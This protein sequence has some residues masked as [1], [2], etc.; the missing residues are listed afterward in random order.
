MGHPGKTEMIVSL[1]PEQL[2][3]TT[4]RPQAPKLRR[5]GDGGRS[6]KKSALV[7]SALVFALSAAPALAT[8]PFAPAQSAANA[9][10]DQK[11]RRQRENMMVMQQ[12]VEEMQTTI[13]PARR[14]H[15]LQAH[16]QKLQDNMTLMRNMSE[17]SMKGHGNDGGRPAGGYGST[18]EHAEEHR[19]AMMQE[20]LDML[21]TMMEQMMVREQL[22]A[23]RPAN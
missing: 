4:N 5:A 21:Q 3:P 14:R 10:L 16:R 6:M 17:L 1:Q 8:D 23:E 13:D 15:L 20:R 9:N 11:M 22:M 12:Q 2:T 18:P 19:Y 7:A